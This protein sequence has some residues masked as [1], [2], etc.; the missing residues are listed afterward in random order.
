MRRRALAVVAVVPF[1]FGFHG[2][3]DDPREPRPVPVDHD[4]ITG[5]RFLA[6]VADAY[7]TVA[8]VEQLKADAEQSARVAA[9]VEHYST[10]VP[11]EGGDSPSPLPSSSSSGR[12]GGDL[13][14]CAVMQCESGG[15]PTAENPSSSVSGKWQFLD[16][17]WD[18]YGGYPR[19]SDVPEDVQDAR[20]REV[21]DGGDGAGHWQQCR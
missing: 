7:A 12:C 19:V 6:D 21:W 14:P 13:P 5:R 20:A 8:W 3:A 1:L 9:A 10:D 11:G 2:P 16:G 15:D 17:T 18:N 4:A